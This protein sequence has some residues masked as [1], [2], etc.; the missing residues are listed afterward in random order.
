MA[1]GSVEVGWGWDVGEFAE[2]DVSLMVLELG[3]VAWVVPSQ[4]EGLAVVWGV[5]WA[6]EDPF[7][8]CVLGLLPHVCRAKFAEL[9]RRVWEKDML[10]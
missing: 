3:W 9:G 5:R 2:N 7:E 10:T 8:T 1:C 4:V 6:R